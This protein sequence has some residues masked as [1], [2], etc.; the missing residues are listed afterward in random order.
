ME[1]IEIYDH[2]KKKNINDPNDEMN[3]YNELIAQEK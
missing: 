1:D 3:Y 2:R